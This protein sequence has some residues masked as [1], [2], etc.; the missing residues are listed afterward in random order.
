MRP[1]PLG[2]VI[3]T[4]FSRLLNVPDG[5]L[6]KKL[7]GSVWFNCYHN[8]LR[9]AENHHIWRVRCNGFRLTFGATIRVTFR[10]VYTQM[11]SHPLRSLKPVSC[12]SFQPIN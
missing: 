7:G 6:Q 10:L 2:Q 12:L 8:R 11:I 9:R 5:L 3:A 4:G 1:V